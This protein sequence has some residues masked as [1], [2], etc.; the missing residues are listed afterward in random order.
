MK[1]FPVNFKIG[2]IDLDAIV[3][4]SEDDHKFKV[5]MVTGEPDPIILRRQTAGSWNVEN[6]GGRRMSP[7]CF[8]DIGKAIDD[9]LNR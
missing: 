8:E 5:E 1:T 9:Y 4:S 6:S 3:T 2:N 7:S